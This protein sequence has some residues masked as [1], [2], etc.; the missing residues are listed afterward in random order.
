MKS[1]LEKVYS[2][3]PNNKVDLK[4]HK[5][6]LGLVDNFNYEY[7]YLEDEIGRL[8]Y[9]VEE[10]FEEKWQE[11]MDAYMPLRDVYINNSESF[12]SEA[13]V[14]G[15]MDVLNEIE[16]KANDLGLDVSD[17]YPD[18]EDHKRQINY[19]EDL[20]KRFDDQKRKIEQF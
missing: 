7:Q 12:I 6:A 5:V 17:V 9:S 16:E 13:D 20:E 1:R 8:S 19:L 2:K 15:D 14:A 11:Y 10:W 18:F 3:M 4:A